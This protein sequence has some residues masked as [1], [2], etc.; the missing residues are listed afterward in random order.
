M[1]FLNVNK[2]GYI[3]KILSIIYFTRF[4]RNNEVG[5]NERRQSKNFRDILK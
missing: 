4:T 3:H 5:V 2:I 1:F